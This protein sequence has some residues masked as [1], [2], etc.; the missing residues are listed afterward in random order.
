MD[1]RRDLEGAVVTIA[2]IIIAAA[3]GGLTLI[4]AAR[5]RAE[6]AAAEELLLAKSRAAR[7]RARVPEVSNNLKGVTASQTIAPY[8]PEE[9]NRAA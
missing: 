3:C 4:Y 7:N 2:L 9:K 8:K 5:K 6:R 1:R